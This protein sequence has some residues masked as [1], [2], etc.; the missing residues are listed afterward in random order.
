[1]PATHAVLLVA[2]GTGFGLAW[3]EAGKFW[4]KVTL[5]SDQ[6]S[7]N[8]QKG[9]AIP[10][11]PQWNADFST[12]YDIPLSDSMKA[13]ATTDWNWTGT[14]HGTVLKMDPDYRRPAYNIL[15]LTAG[16]DLLFDKAVDTLDLVLRGPRPAPGLAGISGA[17]AW[18]DYPSEAGQPHGRAMVQLDPGLWDRD[19]VVTALWDGAPRI[20]VSAI[21]ADKIALNPQTLRPGEDELVLTRLRHVLGKGD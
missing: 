5:T 18:R 13:F 16:V 15:G 4:Y 10:D 8:I 14:S 20:A 6:P 9:D 11:A 17:M 1:L 19:H 21:G 3:V 7:L 12:Q 2:E